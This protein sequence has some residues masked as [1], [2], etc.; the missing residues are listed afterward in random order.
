PP[1]ST[2]CPYTTLFR[3]AALR[4]QLQEIAVETLDVGGEVKLFGD[5]G[6]ADVA[7]GDKAHADVGVRQAVDDRGRDRPDLALGALDQ[8]PHRDRKSTRLNS[9]HVSI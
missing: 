8:R 6:V 2:L 5:I 1:L 7:I 3:S 9:S 4:P